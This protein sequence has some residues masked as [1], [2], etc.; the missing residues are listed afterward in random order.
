MIFHKWWRTPNGF[1][2]L[3]A[4]DRLKSCLIFSEKK[5][6]GFS[7]VSNAGYL[8]STGSQLNRPL[9]L[10]CQ[11]SWRLWW[12]CQIKGMIISTECGNLMVPWFLSRRWRCDHF[13]A[14]FGREGVQS[15]RKGLHLDALLRP[16]PGLPQEAARLQV[17]APGRQEHGRHDQAGDPHPLLHRSHRPLQAEPP[18]GLTIPVLQ[19][20]GGRW[21]CTVFSFSV[22]GLTRRGMV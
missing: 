20:D 16:V 13:S 1:R 3:E 18:G 10:S 2:V 11:R 19:F 9:T 12:R 15:V 8:Q 21:L 4:L 14:G 17:L 6:P 22:S 7:G 5:K